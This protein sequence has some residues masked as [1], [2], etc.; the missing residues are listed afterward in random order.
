ME[1]L[2]DMQDLFYRHY[3]NLDEDMILSINKN[4][5]SPEF[6]NVI[7]GLEE[8]CFSLWLMDNTEK[9]KYRLFYVTNHNK[10]EGDLIELDVDM[11]FRDEL[12]MFFSNFLAQTYKELDTIDVFNTFQRQT[13]SML[14]K[15]GYLTIASTELDKYA[16]QNITIAAKGVKGIIPMLLIRKVEF[17][18]EFFG[19]KK[20][21]RK[22]SEGD[23]IYLM[24]NNRNDYIKIGKSKKPNFREK[25]LQADEPEIELITFWQ[26]PSK[27]ERELH[28][29]F[30]TKR[31]RGE[32]FKLSFIDLK[33]IKEHM[34]P[35]EM[36]G[37]S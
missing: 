13:R 21:D 18:R 4:F 17:Y 1:E 9:I 32:W 3:S 26:A 34:E 25:T 28:R 30:S 29:L 7:V 11:K 22:L 20:L 31:Q 19:N 36:E 16:D 24:L 2:F 6:N 35:Y 27:L 15:I 14:E 33:Q 12:V 8:K 5:N 10:L 37:S 23:H